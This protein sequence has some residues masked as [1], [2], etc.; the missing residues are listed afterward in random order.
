MTMALFSYFHQ[1]YPAISRHFK[2]VDLIF[3]FQ[4]RC[5]WRH[6]LGIKERRISLLSSSPKTNILSCSLP[7]LLPELL[8][9]CC[10]RNLHLDFEY[11]IARS[12]IDAN[13]ITL[14]ASRARNVAWSCLPSTSTQLSFCL[15]HTPYIS[16]SI[17]LLA[18]RPTAWMKRLELR[19][20]IG[21]VGWGAGLLL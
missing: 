1:E 14:Q 20:L 16:L 15:L 17:S 13:P 12:S 3:R 5:R 8:H 10:H 9:L 11:W 19:W 21:I 18:R 4:S 6:L 7:L 2:L